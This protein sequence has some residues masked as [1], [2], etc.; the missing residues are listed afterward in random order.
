MEFV[1]SL[2][3]GM[4]LSAACGFRI[5][6]PLLVTSVAA[7]AGH[8]TLAP[9]FDWI[10]SDAA[11]I[12]FAVATVLEI[13]AYYIPWLDNVLDTISTPTAIVAGTILTASMITDVSPFL[14]WALAVIA[15]GGVAGAVQGATVLVRGAST[16]TTAGLAN[17]VVSTVEMGGSFLTSLL[18]IVAPLAAILLVI[19][20]VG[21]GMKRI[22]APKKK[23]AEPPPVA[24]AS[25][26][27]KA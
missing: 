16:A 9:G 13:L 26:G 10:G 27:Q 4:A 14:Q 25:T 20:I 19:G 12:A 1:L 15:G 18:A 17:P 22:V 23:H 6:I 2:M 8:L 7:N 3:V 21:L 11:L 24:E 5:F